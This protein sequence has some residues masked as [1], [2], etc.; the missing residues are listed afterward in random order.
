MLPALAPVRGL[1]VALGGCSQA[2]VDFGQPDYQPRDHRVDPGLEERDPGGDPE[3]QV[4]GADAHPQ[5]ARDRDHGEDGQASNQRHHADA[6]AIGKPDHDNP[7]HV[8]AFRCPCR[9]T[10]LGDQPMTVELGI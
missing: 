4:D 8:R 6:A 2:G 3:P 7:G 9:S 1:A 5:P 10:G